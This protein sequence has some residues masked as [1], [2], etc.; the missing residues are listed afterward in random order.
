MNQPPNETVDPNVASAELAVMMAGLLETA[1]CNENAELA[2]L[3]IARTTAMML[4]RLPVS[5]RMRLASAFK[6]QV[7]ASTK[8]VV[9][10]LAKLGQKPSGLI[11]PETP[12]ILL[13]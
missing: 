10:H 3:A 12:S 13:N 4:G 7:D 11:L 5:D 1:G 8:E 6:R 2:L 9:D